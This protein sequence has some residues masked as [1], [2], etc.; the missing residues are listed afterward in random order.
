MHKPS[1]IPRRGFLVNAAALLALPAL[2]TRADAAPSPYAID[3]GNAQIK[4]LFDLNGTTQSGTAPLSTASLVIDPDN[5]AASTA[6]VSAD[7]S[8][9][10]TGLIFATDALK[11]EK[12][13]HTARY[14]VAR[15]RSTKVILGRGGRISEGAALEGKL[16]L[17]G[18]TRSIRLNA[19]LFRP[20]GTDADDLSE[21]D[22]HLRGTLSR[23]AYGAVGYPNLVA[24]T[25]G[26]NIRAKIR[27][28]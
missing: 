2:C 28:V 25:V 10:R 4:F 14:P 3:A 19:D 11:S 21:L 18:V 7:V 23:S 17:R 1:R 12:V 22:V 6:D 27:R 13:L 8:R 9:A 26:L 16:T 20:T 5:L 15:F 24:D